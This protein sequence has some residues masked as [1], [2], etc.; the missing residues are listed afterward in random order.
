MKVPNSDRI[1][2]V[3]IRR[4]DL[5]TTLQAL[6]VVIQATNKDHIPNDQVIQARNVLGSALSDFDVTSMRKEAPGHGKAAEF[7]ET[8]KADFK[9]E[10]GS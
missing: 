6:N 5:V 1:I 7:Q 2:T 4:G 10:T 9:A 3:K 8:G